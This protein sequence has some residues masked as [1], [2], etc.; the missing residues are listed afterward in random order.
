MTDIFMYLG[1]CAI[2]YALGVPLRKAKDKLKW[3]GTAQS[4][5]VIA[6]VVIMG[7]R[8]GSNDDI[9]ANLGSYGIYSA[10]YTLAILFMSVLCVSITRRFL[11]LNKYGLVQLEPCTEKENKE[12]RDEKSGGKIDKMTIFI[13][14]GVVIGILAGYFFCQDL[15]PDKAAFEGGISL[16]IT[17]GLCILLVFVGLDLGLEG[18]IINNFKNAGLRILA[19]PVAIAIGT[20]GGAAVCSVLLPVSLS[21]SLAIGAGMGWYSLGAGILMDAGH[22]TAGAISFMHNVMREVFSIILIPIVA[23]YVGHVETVALP[24]SPAMDVCLPIVEKST[25]GTV[26]VYSFISGC[27]LSI[28]VPFLVPL[29]I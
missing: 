7:A 19:I 25:S 6:L 28:S 4:I 15:F 20:L 27:A 8:I 17:V 14:S 5:S 3:I 21:E 10:I 26:A 29:F 11:K 9:V 24:G 22:V 23:K 18:Q 13:I 1:F 12:S 16:C 2:G